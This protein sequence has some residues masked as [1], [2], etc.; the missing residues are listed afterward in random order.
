MT[1]PTRCDR[2][3]LK[4]YLDGELPLRTRLAVQFHLLRCGDCRREKHEMKDISSRLKAGDAG[5]LGDAL[6]TKILSAVPDAAPDIP[7]NAL[8]LRSRFSPNRKRIPVYAFGASATALV[9]WFVLFPALSGEREKQQQLAVAPNAKQISLAAGQYAQDYD[10]TYGAASQSAKLDKSRAYAGAAPA[11]PASAGK[12]KAFEQVATKPETLE[13]LKPGNI[14]A[15]APKITGARADE[16]ERKVH[17]EASLTL[18]VDKTEAKSETIS[19]MTKT[20]GGYVAS[21]ELHTEDDGTKTA[22]L[23]LKIPISQFD[24]L[25]SQLSHLGEVKAKSLSGEDIT[26]KTSDQE[27]TVRVVEGDAKEL[28]AKLQKARHASRRDEESLRDL[29]IREAQSKAHLKLLRNL[30]ALADI[31]VELREKP[32]PEPP[33]P[34]TGG[35]INDMNDTAHSAIAAF[36]QAARLPIVLLIWAVVY[37]PLFLVLAVAYRVASR[38]LTRFTP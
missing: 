9:G 8:P 28:E 37:L 23:T 1:Q 22:S 7:P 15:A 36:S 14:S 19:T 25:L 27:Q 30:A 20:A 6:R 13:T 2:D 38:F 33:K 3:N 12:Q 16:A 11:A 17:R 31:T 21:D 5:I 26:E 18:E 35:F 10:A 32:K 34:Q 29:R 4:A 24:S